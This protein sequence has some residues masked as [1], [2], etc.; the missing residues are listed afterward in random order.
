MGPGSF[1]INCTDNI[2]P[3]AHVPVLSDDGLV[4][5][6]QGIC[7]FTGPSANLCTHLFYSGG[8]E[9]LWREL[10]RGRFEI[11]D[12]IT[13]GFRGLM[14]VIVSSARVSMALPQQVR[15]NYLVKPTLSEAALRQ[16]NEKFAA[17]FPRL[18]KKQAQLVKAK[19]TDESE[20]P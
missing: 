16:Q 12:K 15:E 7:G 5:S 6:P 19:W 9:P 3:Q 1:I 13:G 2:K 11:K 8:L 10:P 4:L 18:V 17:A 14:Q 20:Q